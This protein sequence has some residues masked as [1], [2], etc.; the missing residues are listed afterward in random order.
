MMF[1]ALFFVDLVLVALVV[2]VFFIHL[3]TADLE[4]AVIVAVEVFIAA[5]SPPRHRLVVV[6]HS[7]YVGTSSSLH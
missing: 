6:H 3:E 7:S 5:R 1:S 4:T 2:I